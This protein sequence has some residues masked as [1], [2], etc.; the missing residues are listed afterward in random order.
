[1]ALERGIPSHVFAARMLARCARLSR[2]TSMPVV[3]ERTRPLK[4][5]MFIPGRELVMTS[6]EIMTQI[7]SKTDLFIADLHVC[8]A[9]HR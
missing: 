9:W 1:M 8:V 5:T 7:F 6:K 2:A 4:L 3:Q